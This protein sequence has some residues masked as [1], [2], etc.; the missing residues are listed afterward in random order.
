MFTDN[1]VTEIYCLADDFCKFFDS[2]LKRYSLESPTT[3]RNYYRAPRMS[4]AEVMLIVILF[5]A[6]GYRCLKHYYLDYVSVHLRHLFPKLVSYNRFVEL[7]KDVA[8]PL[9]IFIKKGSTEGLY[10]H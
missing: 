6:S 4:K 2:L 10:R 1:K 5:H 9:A 8:L 7:E 3:K